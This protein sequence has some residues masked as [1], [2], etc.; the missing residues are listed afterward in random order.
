MKQ[1]LPASGKRIVLHY[2]SSDTLVNGS[3]VKNTQKPSAKRDVKNLG[4]LK[5]CKCAP[6]AE[7]LRTI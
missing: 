4:A 7:H 2:Y 3:A 6:A 1:N 5:I